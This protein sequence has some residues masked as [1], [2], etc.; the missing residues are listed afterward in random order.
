MTHI[1]ESDIFH[2]VELY[3]IK[4]NIKSPIQISSLYYKG[5]KYNINC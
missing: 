5:N 1:Y 4:A 3:Y 2:C